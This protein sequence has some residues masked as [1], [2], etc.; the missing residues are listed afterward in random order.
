M[1]IL[2]T[3][4][5]IDHIRQ[6]KEESRLFSL[7]K[8]FPNDLAIS[9]ITVQELYEGK[10]TRELKKEQE[11]LDILNG[12]TIL[13]YDY[14]IAKKAGEIARDLKTPM[15]FTDSAIAAT[16]IV[17]KAKLSTLNSKDFKDIKELEL[18]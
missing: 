10:S 4:I 18:V 17:Y 5:I 2:D 6:R 13:Q 3:S 7:A 14:V 12:L 16:A 8:E 9:L 15:E 1:V 11:L